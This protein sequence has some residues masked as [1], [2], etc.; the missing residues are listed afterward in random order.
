MASLC[1]VC[2]LSWTAQF[3]VC[4]MDLDLGGFLKAV[5]EYVDRCHMQT[6]TNSTELVWIHKSLTTT[7][8][9]QTRI[10]HL[11]FLWP[12]SPPPGGVAKIVADAV[13][14]VVVVVGGRAPS[15]PTTQKP[16][17]PNADEAEK[18]IRCRTMGVVVSTKSIACSAVQ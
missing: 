1:F 12:G 10:T 16:A 9:T 8:T 5:I 7:T 2:A 6:D 17:K 18:A 15:P 4:N 11:L 13:P 14:R 3:N